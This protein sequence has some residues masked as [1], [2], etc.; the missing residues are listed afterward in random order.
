VGGGRET[1]AELVVL[2]I[3]SFTS[4]IP[5]T[6]GLVQSGRIPSFIFWMSVL[7]FFLIENKQLRSVLVPYTV[8]YFLLMV[9]TTRWDHMSIPL[10][11]L[12]SCNGVFLLMK[13]GEYIRKKSLKA[14]YALI[15]IPLALTFWMD[16]EGFV[17][18]GLCDMPYD[19][20]KELN[21]YINQ[22]TGTGDVVVTLTYLAPDIKAKTTVFENFLPYNGY[23]F[24]YMRREYGINE[25]AYNISIENIDYIVIPEGTLETLEYKSLIEKFREWNVVYRVDYV[26]KGS[27]GL[28]DYVPE[29]FND[30]KCESHYVVLEN[31]GRTR[32]YV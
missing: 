24:A 14:I 17:A 15:L 4:I 18:G 1:P 8:G 5:V 28:R 9:S 31:P 32:D 22:N 12:L 21:S 27:C 20:L 19:G 13:A 6:M 11:F 29:P 7:G 30:Y 25:F 26:R 3:L 10:A 2:A 23:G 16:V